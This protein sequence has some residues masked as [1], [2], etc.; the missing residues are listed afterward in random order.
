[1]G[2]AMSILSNG[3]G[4]QRGA[5]VKSL[6]GDVQRCARHRFASGVLVQALTQCSTR[7]SRQLVIALT[8]QRGT[9]VDLAC[10]NFGVHVIRALAELP[11]FEKEVL[12]QVTRALKRVEKDEYGKILLQDLG[13]AGSV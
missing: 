13:L 8:Q 12:Q 2:I 7:E 5:V 9:V 4:S 11:E 3:T 6:L 1:M 10:H